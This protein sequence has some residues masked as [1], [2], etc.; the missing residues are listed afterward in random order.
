LKYLAFVAFSVE[1]SSL[2]DKVVLDVA[3]GR[4]F[5][6]FAIDKAIRHMI[7][8]RQRVLCRQDFSVFDL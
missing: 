8:G 1:E 7:V 5:F 2:I 4:P 6:E 3:D